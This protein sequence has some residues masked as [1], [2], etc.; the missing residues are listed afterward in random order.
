MTRRSF[1]AARSI[2]QSPALSTYGLPQARVSD[3]G[4][5]HLARATG[6]EPD[7]TL[8]E[9]AI[10]AAATL[11]LPAAPQLVPIAVPRRP[12]LVLQADATWFEWST[13]R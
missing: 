9:R 10:E 2:L 7:V 12:G 4:R 1:A 3:V 6:R 11:L 5:M 13:P 8:L